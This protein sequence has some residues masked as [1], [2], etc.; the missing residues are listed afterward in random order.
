MEDGHE[1]RDGVNAFR[2]PQLGF[3]LGGETLP[4]GINGAY[5]YTR[6]Y[7]RF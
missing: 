6:L 1:R 5:F 4:F 2:L 7:W 3:T